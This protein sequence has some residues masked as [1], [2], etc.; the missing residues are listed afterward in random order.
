M[1]KLTLTND[2]KFLTLI[3]SYDQRHIPKKIG[4]RWNPSMK[5]W[6]FAIDLTLYSEIQKAFGNSLEITDQ[7][8]QIIQNKIIQDN[9]IKKFKEQAK[10]NQDINYSVPGLLFN[11]KNPLFDYQKH[12]VRCG[13]VAQGG[14]LIAD[15]MGLGKA[16]AIDQPILTPFGKREIGKLKV[17]DQVIG[18]NGLPTSVI[19]VYPQGKKQLYRITFNDGYYIDCCGEHLWNVASYNSGENTKGNRTYYRTLSVEQMLNKQLQLQQFGIGHN[20]TKVYKY[21]TYYKTKRNGNKWQIPIVQPIQFNRND[22]LV[23]QPYLLGLILGDGS[24]KNRHVRF[25][26]SK[27]DFD[28]LFCNYINN[29]YS[30]TLHPIVLQN[31]RDVTFHFYN[32]QLQMLGIAMHRSWQK[33]I[34]Q[35]YKYSSI[36]NRLAILQG[37]MDTD[38]NCM[39]RNKNRTN[40]RIFSGTQ[41]ATVSQQLANDVADIVHSLGGIV[42]RRQKIG[43]YKKKNGERVFCRRVYRLNIKLP[44]QFNPFRLSRKSSVYNPPEFYKVGRF[45]KNIQPI[46]NRQCVCIAVDAQDKL[47]VANHAIV[48]HNTIQ[49]IGIALNKKILNHARQ[50]LVVCPACV[51]YNWLNQIQKFTKEKALVIDGKV[52]QRYQKW[53]ATGYYFKIVNYE[54]LV[55]DLFYVQKTDKLGNVTSKD[56]RIPDCQQLIDNYFQAMVIDEAHYLSSTNALRT[57]ACKGMKVKTKIALTGT[58]V[59]GRLS[60]MY[61]IMQV[62]KPGL[63]PTRAKFLQRYAIFDHF[64]GVKQWVRIDQFKNKIQPYYIRRLKNDVL[65]SLPPM[66]IQTMYA[67]FSDKAAKQYKKLVKG[68]CDL[69]FNDQMLVRI[70]RARQFCNC[71]SIL[72]KQYQKI[73]KDKLSVFKDLCTELIKQNGHKIVVFSQYRETVNVLLQELQKQKYQVVL[74]KSFKNKFQGAQ[75][76]NNSKTANVFLCTDQGMTGL[77]L[78]SAQYLI[79]YDVSW[80]PA[81]NLQRY[82]RIHRANT[83]HTANIINLVVKD[84][85]QERILQAIEDKLVLSDNVLDQNFTDAVITQP[86][87]TRDLYN[88]L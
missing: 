11:G 12:G 62:I 47:Y 85:I 53:F 65:K 84:T 45:I 86:I 76:F 82:A 21:N 51:K 28:Q 15:Q 87:S 77:N 29:N 81:V 48:T 4:G 5:S 57:L 33:F 67:Q 78:G 10:K 52:Q 49:G 44:N 80:S 9:T 20:S 75:Y 2:K 55:R 56:N 66:I 27:Y 36:Q 32:K 18:S 69:T 88:M 23:I 43:S 17:G 64:G 24:V 6:D 31:L 63:F 25:S 74:L 70:I 79:N 54:I 3:C 71:P 59:N 26:V 14:F 60:Q 34:P 83:K 8:R 72:G 19:G 58:P 37:L 7:A 38:G 22:Q 41:F 50:C 1:S 68:D 30:Y 13:T 39:K 35:Q 42:R 40:E 46:G 16:L 73:S 61:S